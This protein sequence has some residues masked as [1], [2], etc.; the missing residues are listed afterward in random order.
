MYLYYR[1]WLYLLRGDLDAC[2]RDIDECLEKGKA[3]GVPNFDMHTLIGR[4]I[5]LNRMKRYDDA[6]KSID[7]IRTDVIGTESPLFDF[8]MLTVEAETAFDSGDE[9][10]GK[11]LLAQAFE[12]G[13]VHGQIGAAQWVT[14]L[15]SKLAGAALRFGIEPMY[16]TELI[17][18]R[19]LTAPSPDIENWPWPYKILTL[20]RFELWCDGTVY[21]P[22]R[23]V[24]DLLKI[25]VASGSRGTSTD[26]L[27]ES[28]WPDLD[29][30]SAKNTLKSSLHRLRKLLVNDDAILLRENN[31]SLNYSLFWIDAHYFE[32]T[33]DEVQ[34]RAA[35]KNNGSIET[36]TKQLLRSYPG[37]FLP[38]ETD[39]KELVVVRDRL[40]TKFR[41]AILRLGK[42]LESS[43]STSAAI[44]IYQRSLDLDNLC[45][46]IYQRLIEV[47]VKHGNNAEALNVYRR[48]R[49]ILSIVLGVA[50][51]AETQSKVAT[52]RV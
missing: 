25:L 21:A 12:I 37:H 7:R 46:E 5:V 52:L 47:H 33:V 8:S 23:K 22:V 10:N 39:I 38:E 43:G 28:L 2:L 34:D 17:K 24:L 13:R 18:K 11:T 32:K 42:T 31:I 49:E 4:A 29:G 15:M 48:C 26:A 36:Q 50:P 44:E 41:R 14:P 3:C 45:E 20:G 19:Q 35:D 6:R 9:A 30:D 16:T 51:S 1:A 40:R 27:L